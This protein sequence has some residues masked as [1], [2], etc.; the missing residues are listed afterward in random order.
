MLTGD[1]GGDGES[2]DIME[3]SKLNENKLMLS[4]ITLNPGIKFKTQEDRF[5]NS[6][7]GGFLPLSDVII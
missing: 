1:D 3:M 6:R 5:L 7:K 2:N 4:H